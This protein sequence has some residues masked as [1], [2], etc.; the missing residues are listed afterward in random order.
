MQVK[1]KL[2]RHRCVE[3]PGVLTYSTLYMDQAS[4]RGPTASPHA[5]TASCGAVN[6]DWAREF[7]DHL[8]RTGMT[9]AVSCDRGS[10]REQLPSCVHHTLF[11]HEFWTGSTDLS[12]CRRWHSRD[13]PTWEPHLVRPM[14]RRLRSFADIMSLLPNR[15]LWLH[16]DSIMLQLCD[17]AACAL[18]RAGVAPTPVYPHMPPW[19]AEAEQAGGLSLGRSTLLSSNGARLIC[20]G[21]G[22]FD[23]RQARAM[24]PHV[25]A[26]MLNHGLH[27]HSVD[28]F[29]TTVRAAMTELRSWRNAAPTRVALWR[30]GSA[31]HFQGG[32]YV[33]GAELGQCQ[34]AALSV[35]PGSQPPGASAGSNLN[36]AFTEVE[37]RLAL[38]YGVGLVPF[39]NLTAPRHDMH[40]ADFRT[41]H[42]RGERI[43]DCTHFCYTPLFWDHTFDAMYSVLQE[44]LGLQ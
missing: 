33:P 5:T 7:P 41:K 6:D 3:N 30:E 35:A 32:S 14:A 18:V 1:R 22:P 21:H 40:Y 26:V 31:Q 29:S 39:F 2:G 27:Y 24:L 11:V 23:A 9:A 19:A 16:G 15:T 8:A 25:D 38:Q 34:C 37:R 12:R 44:Q 4:R 43:C 10:A 17:A 36:V 20:T 42:Q 13:W 28:A